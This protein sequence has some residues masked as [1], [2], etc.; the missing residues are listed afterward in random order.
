MNRFG[1]CLPV[2]KHDKS[3]RVN[4]QGDGER[5]SCSVTAGL[6][7]RR[8]LFRS[9]SDGGALPRRRYAIFLK[10]I[11]GFIRLYKYR[12]YLGLA[13]QTRLD[14]GL[15]ATPKCPRPLLSAA[16]AGVLSVAT[17]SIAGI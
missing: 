14:D 3:R 16:V 12:W 2:W 11:G 13:Q 9:F 5:F 10:P 15:P 7:D 4:F 1:R 8:K 6:A 17:I